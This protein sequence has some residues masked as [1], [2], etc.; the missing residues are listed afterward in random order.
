[1]SEEKTIMFY[2]TYIK[3]KTTRITEA[4][5]I[6]PNAQWVNFLFWHVKI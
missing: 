4:Y 1:M 5:L 6:D 3:Q 2:V